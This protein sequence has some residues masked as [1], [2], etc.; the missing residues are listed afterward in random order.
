MP[1]PES[2]LNQPDAPARPAIAAKQLILPIALFVIVGVP[3]VAV[4]WDTL[5]RLFAGQV[6]WTWIGAAVVAAVLLGVLLKILARTLGRW[7]ARRTD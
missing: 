1:S 4:I 7:Q 2:S 5:N 3:L 6:D